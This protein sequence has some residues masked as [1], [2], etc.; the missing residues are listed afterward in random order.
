MSSLFSS[1][2][3]YIQ[4]KDDVEFTEKDFNNLLDGIGKL[5]DEIDGPS[6]STNSKKTNKKDEIINKKKTDKKEEACSIQ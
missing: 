6:S 4:T 3:L 2:F 5:L 1:F